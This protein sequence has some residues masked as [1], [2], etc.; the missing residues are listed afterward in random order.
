MSRYFRSL[1][2]IVLIAALPLP[3]SAQT[4][5][6]TEPVCTAALRHQWQRRV[7]HRRI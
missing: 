5:I 7:R 1:I 3:V 4:S 2:L 6:E